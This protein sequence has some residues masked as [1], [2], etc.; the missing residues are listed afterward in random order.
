MPISIASGKRLRGSTRRSSASYSPNASS[1]SSVMLTSSPTSL[2]SRACST[3]GKTPPKPPW[4][5]SSSAPSSSSAWPSQ[6]RSS[7]RSRT[8]LPRSIGMLAVGERLAD[9]EDFVDVRLRVHVLED[10]PHHALLVDDEGRAQQ[11]RLRVAVDDLVL[12]HVVEAADLL[13]GIGEELLGEP[14][15]VAKRL[16]R[17]HLPDRHAE[18]DG[19]ELLEFVLAVA[20]ADRLDRARG[21]AVLRIE[22]QDD[23]LLATVAGEVR[24]L[25]ARVR[26]LEGWCW[27]T[28]V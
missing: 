15:H 28:Y 7:Y 5:Y 2:P 3:L 14:V 4:R 10:V 13:L 11:A 8:T 6:S 16:V 9:L 26:Q 1:G 20:E 22:I 23:V 17:E 27:L 24:H 19:V 12:D 25:H 18:D 21:R